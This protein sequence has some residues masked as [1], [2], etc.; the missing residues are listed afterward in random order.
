[1]VTFSWGLGNF[2]LAISND[3]NKKNK[4]VGDTCLS[5]KVEMIDF[6]SIPFIALSSQ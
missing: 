5:G 2:L 4:V 6:N 1:M 3:L